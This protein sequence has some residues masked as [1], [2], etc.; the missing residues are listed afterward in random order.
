MSSDSSQNEPLRLALA[1][2]ELQFGGAER[3]LVN[4]ATGLDRRQFE[5]MVYSL[6]PRPSGDRAALVER[7]EHADIETHFLDVTSRW[8]FLTAVRR[9]RR[10]LATQMPDILQTFLFHANVVGAIA[11]RRAGVKSI[12]AGIRVA[13][14]NH[15]RLRVERMALRRA[16]QIVCVSRSVADYSQ[17]EGNLPAGKLL[18]IPNGIDLS[19]DLSTAK[20]DLPALGITPA[21]CVIACVGRLEEQKGVDWLLELAPHILTALPQ[22]DLLLVGDG[23]QRGNLEALA[24]ERKIADRVHF[25][26]WRAD[27]AAILQSSDLLVLPSR[28]EGMPN[29]LL[30]A[31]AAGLPVV[32]TQVSGVE[33]LLGPNDSQQTASVGD[34][35][36]FSERVITIASDQNLSASLGEKNRQRVEEH[37]S[38]Q[39]M[40]SAFESLYRKLAKF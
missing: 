21:R 13:E 23:D 12:V 17:S 14:P 6:G 7:L 40:V 35:D 4:L 22:H 15:W 31:M 10:L 38:L 36:A 18:V 34:G 8:Q 25:A 9:L 16:A 29:V 5:P 28:W 33:E 3:A 26:G 37:F 1:I 2:T 20:A 11:G 30:E 32:A 39:N 24:R 19:E 27:V